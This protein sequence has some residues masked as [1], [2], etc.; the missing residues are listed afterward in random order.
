MKPSS[1]FVHAGHSKAAACDGAHPGLTMRLQETKD[2][3]R[4]RI[5]FLP[6][7]GD[8]RNVIVIG[9]VDQFGGVAGGQ[10]RSVECARF[11]GERRIVV[12]AIGD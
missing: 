4:R 3:A 5:V 11:G 2:S 10:Q 1:R 12:L 9:D 8:L 7:F 6:E